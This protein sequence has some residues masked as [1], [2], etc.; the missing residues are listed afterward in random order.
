[1]FTYQVSVK[2]DLFSFTKKYLLPWVTDGTCYSG[3]KQAGV[4]LR[5]NFRN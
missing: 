1:M 3:N 4:T 5:L 2:L